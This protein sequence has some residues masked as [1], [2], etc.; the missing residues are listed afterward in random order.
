MAPV[1]TIGVTTYNR[2][3]MLKECLASIL[4][5][6]FSNFEVVVGNDYP[7]ET[8]SAELLSVD[9]PRIRFVNYPQNL[10][11]VQNMNALLEMASGRYFTWLADDDMY[12]PSFLQAMYTAL[13]NF[14]F[15]PCIFSSYKTGSVFTEEL[16]TISDE[17][18]I[19]EGRQFVHLYLSRKLKTIGCYGVYER[20]YLTEIGGFPNLGD[21]MYGDNL[22]AIRTAL[23]TRVAYINVPLV[24]FRT[25]EQSFSYTSKDL[26]G[27]RRAQ[28]ALCCECIKI[29]KD[30]KLSN[31][32]YMHFFLLLKWCINDFT[33]VI[34]R[35][36][37]V[38]GNQITSYL[39]FVRKS[40]DLLKGS[41]FYWRLFVFSSL[42]ASKLIFNLLK[43]RLKHYLGFRNR[44]DIPQ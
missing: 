44:M 2:K 25:H 40:L 1:F 26:D 39:N 38:T 19:M 14:N 28:E 11:E 32:F 20:E 17:G 22:L 41:V 9:D 16:C 3:A 33:N 15:P 31:F 23:L 36:T 34:L 18:Q 43:K 29:F 10:G 13:T 6:T 8:L 27:Y 35:A 42:A 37:R 24:F 30:E 7:E 21:S 4:G 5:Q 12:A